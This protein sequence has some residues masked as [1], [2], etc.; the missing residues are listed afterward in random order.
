MLEKVQTYDLERIQEPFCIVG[1]IFKRQKNDGEE[2]K[3][4][5]ILTLFFKHI[6]NQQTNYT[7]LKSHKTRD[8]TSKFSRLGN[9]KNFCTGIELKLASEDPPKTTLINVRSSTDSTQ[10]IDSVTLKE[11]SETKTETQ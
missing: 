10:M 6:L 5:Q 7:S 1:E 3:R 11:L 8:Q 9:K 2:I 4:C